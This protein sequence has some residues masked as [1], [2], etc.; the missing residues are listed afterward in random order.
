VTDGTSAGTTMFADIYPGGSA[1]HQIRP[2]L[3][4]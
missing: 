4:C 2:I 3:S 1:T